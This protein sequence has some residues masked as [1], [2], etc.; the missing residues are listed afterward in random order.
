M[1]AP[2]TAPARG[3]LAAV[4]PLVVCDTAEAERAHARAVLGPMSTLLDTLP[5]TPLIPPAAD[6]RDALLAT[7]GMDPGE[8][9]NWLFLLGDQIAAHI[10][11]GGTV[12]MADADGTSAPL[13]MPSP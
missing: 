7:M 1:N 11:A 9:V 4:V 8:L 13:E 12:M 6:A 2:R 3:H 5:E 10:A